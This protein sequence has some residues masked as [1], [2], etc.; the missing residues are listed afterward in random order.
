M[1]AIFCGIVLGICVAQRGSAVT[2]IAGVL[3]IIAV[4]APA[5]LIP[6]V[7]IGALAVAAGCAVVGYNMGLAVAVLAAVAEPYLPRRNA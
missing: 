4:A 2:C 3:A 5:L 7:K 6:D 1:I